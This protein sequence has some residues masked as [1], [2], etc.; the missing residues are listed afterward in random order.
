MFALLAKV[1]RR[2]TK[3]VSPSLIGINEKKSNIAKNQ[4]VSTN[5]RM[6]L[7]VTDR[8]TKMVK[9]SQEVFRIFARVD[10]SATRSNLPSANQ[11]AILLQW[12]TV[13]GSIQDLPR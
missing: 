10:I 13:E 6:L 11:E 3:L 2:H 4:A 8:M 5:L 7:N 12:H 1:A 9:K